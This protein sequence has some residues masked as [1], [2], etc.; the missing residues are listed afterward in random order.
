MSSKRIFSAFCA[1]NLIAV[2]WGANVNAQ[3]QEQPQ[4]QPQSEHHPKPP[5]PAIDACNGKKSGDSVTFIGR[6]NEKINGIC[7]QMGD[8][9]AARPVG[10]T[11]HDATN[12]GN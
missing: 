10:G 5:Q 9:L 2:L 12:G 3:P 6:Y 8:V 11:P 4:G 1:V 7:T